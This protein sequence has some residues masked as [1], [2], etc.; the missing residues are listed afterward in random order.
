VTPWPPGTHF[1]DFLAMSWDIRMMKQALRLTCLTF[2]AT[3]LVITACTAIAWALEHTADSLETVKERIAEKKAVLVDVR[4]LVEWNAGHI[5]D[6]V[7]LSFRD[8]QDNWDEEK[9]REKVSKDLIV[10]TYCVVGFRSLKAGAIL[11]KAGYDVRPLK[12]GYDELVKAGF[13]V[14][15]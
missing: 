4:D 10:Y 2:V 3:L 11:E 14:E 7:H 8:L 15:K 1:D 6:A 12:P 5:K 13:E 9:V